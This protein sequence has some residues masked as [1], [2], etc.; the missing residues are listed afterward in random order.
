MFAERG[1]HVLD[2]PISGGPAGARSGKLA[3][4]VGGD[5]AIFARCRDVLTAMGDQVMY[6]GPI[7]AGSVTKLVH[8]SAG[9]AIQTAL[10]EAFTLGVKA[11]VEPLALWRAVR[12]G[13]GGRRRTF[14][15]LVDQFLPGT[16]DTPAFALRLARKDVTLATD[17]GRELRVP[18]RADQYG[19]GGVDR[20]REPRLGSARL[21]GGHAAPGR[22]RAGPHPG[23]SC[24]PTGGDRLTPASMP[25]TALV[26]AKGFLEPLGDDRR[27]DFGVQHHAGLRAGIEPVA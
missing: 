15:G 23:R 10:A 21:A 1:V 22:A 26:A 4:W 6:V 18:M 19:S 25:Q 11:G 14:D 9:Y 24:R 7:G 13:A 2:A 27:H 5:E 3:I 20:S 12:Q 16:F 8:N 17:L